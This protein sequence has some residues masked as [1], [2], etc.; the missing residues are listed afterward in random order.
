VIW[1]K[2]GTSFAD[3]DGVRLLLFAG[4]DKVV[5]QACSGVSRRDVRFARAYLHTGLS[6]WLD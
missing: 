5:V 2:A 1:G 6:P 3:V 4:R